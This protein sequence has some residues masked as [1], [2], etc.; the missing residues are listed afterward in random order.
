MF[1]PLKTSLKR[2]RHLD[3]EVWFCFQLGGEGVWKW[4]VLGLSFL[5]FP[6]A[7]ICET[8]VGFPVGGEIKGLSALARLQQEGFSVDPGL[9]L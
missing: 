4:E 6:K 1:T 9:R 3:Y 2:C 5:P 7:Q 8:A